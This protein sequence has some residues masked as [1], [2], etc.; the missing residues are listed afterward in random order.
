[1]VRSIT[2]RWDGAERR[3]YRRTL[4]DIQLAVAIIIKS[5]GDSRE[6]HVWTDDSGKPK[7]H[8]AS[9]VRNVSAGGV[10]FQIP[11]SA[12]LETLVSIMIDFPRKKKHI[13]CNGRVVRVKPV[14]T[15]RSYNW[16]VE[17]TDIKDEDQQWVQAYTQQQ[18]RRRQGFLGRL[19]RSS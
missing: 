10:S 11:R 17:F 2:S 5:S 16:G 14:I 19:F 15:E 7:F 4:G 6:V 1:M 18:M 8:P 12:S 13:E 9:Q 3:K